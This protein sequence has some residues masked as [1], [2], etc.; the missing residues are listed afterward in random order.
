LSDSVFAGLTVRA[1]RRHGL[2][3]GQGRQIAGH[4]FDRPAKIRESNAGIFSFDLNF[5]PFQFLISLSPFFFFRFLSAIVFVHFL[6]Q[7][8]FGT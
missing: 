7:G 4:V 1:R 5:S 8:L 3:S 2:L 6:L